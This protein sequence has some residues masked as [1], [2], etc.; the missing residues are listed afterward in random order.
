[1]II[2]ITEHRVD[3]KITLTQLTVATFLFIV[4]GKV[5]MVFYIERDTKTKND[6]LTFFQLT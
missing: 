3:K 1:M 4:G 5:M 6:K 2:T